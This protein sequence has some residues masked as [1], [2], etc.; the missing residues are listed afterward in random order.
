MNYYCYY[1]N[2]SRKS[3]TPEVCVEWFRRSSGDKSREMA[4]NVRVRINNDD[5]LLAPVYL[6]R[7]ELP[8]L[9][10]FNDD[11]YLTDDSVMRLADDVDADR[12]ADAD[13]DVVQDDDID[14]TDDNYDKSP[15]VFASPANP[16]SGHSD[17]DRQVLLQLHH[18]Q[19][20]LSA[21]KNRPSAYSD[22]GNSPI[23]LF[24]TPINNISNDRS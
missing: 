22:D 24:N 5:P 9:V 19:Q 12:V 2:W 23:P 6:S 3:R 8:S 14:I 21:F 7:K 16:L 11:L 17:Q 4:S 13:D 15:P 1:F 10:D 18:L 20:I